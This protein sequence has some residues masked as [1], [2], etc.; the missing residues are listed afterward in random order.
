MTRSLILPFIALSAAAIAI[1]A[2]VAFHSR[3]KKSSLEALRLV[4]RLASVEKDL[5]P[6][7]FVLVEGE[8]WPA[9]ARGGQTIAR[10]CASVRVV[11]A[12]GHHLEVEPLG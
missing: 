2:Y 3:Q 5:R 12:R 9:R 6:E 4:G 8:L 1:L 7:G 11:G 10:G